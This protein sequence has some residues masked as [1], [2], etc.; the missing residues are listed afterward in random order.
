MSMT[1]RR[2][3]VAATQLVLI[4]ILLAPASATQSSSRELRLRAADFSYN[5]DHD[6]ALALLRQA[7]AADPNDSVNH[8]EL[9]ATVWL[10]V[11]FQSGA[12]TVDH[13]LG[14]FASANAQAK[15]PPQELDAEFKREISKAIELAE[16][17]VT[18]A[19]RDPQAHFDLGTALGL[20]AT[21]MASVEGHL[22]AGFRAA[23][24]SYEEEERVQELDPKRK[25]AGLIVGTY[26]YIVSTLALPMRL[27]AYM[28]GFS[29]GK[30]VGLKM[31]EETAATPGENR[32]DAQF[33]LVLLYNRERRYDDAMHML[34][35]LR[36]EYP[37]NRLVLLEAGATAV[38]AGRAAEADQLLTEGIAALPRD[39][40]PRIPGEEALWHYKRGAARVMLGR[41][42]DALTDLHI[43]I[44]P[45]AAGWV[46][47][48]AHVELARLA[49]AQ[50]D[51]ETVRREAEA[52]AALCE[53][54]G[55]PFCV[56]EAKK[57]K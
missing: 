5:L 12:V 13:Y 45:G 38:R 32:T 2:P 31:I 46:Q 26:R 19:P 25:D 40:R 9:A 54:N 37:R 23:R 7:I 42:E 21:Y 41:R 29:G 18:A 55:D 49:L 28:S 30:E 1:A 56:A 33:T 39:P 11:L 3:S 43:A 53:K 15:Q 57:L 20:Q 24:R 47:G 8:R 48:R 34:N 17:R 51:H 52:A 50:G 6:E 22:L 10:D 36:R 14:S 16:K 35:D 4:G 44:T 27:M